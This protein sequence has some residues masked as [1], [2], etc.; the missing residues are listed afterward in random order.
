M[1]GLEEAESGCVRVSWL[2]N[3]DVSAKDLLATPQ[4]QEHADARSE[5]IEFLNEVLI[6]G[7]VAA[8][9]VKAEAEDAGIS[10]RTL[11]R[12]KKAIGIM[13]YREGETGE[14]GKGQWLW[15]L[16]VLEL[17][18]DNIKDATTIKDAKGCQNNNIGILNHT[19]DSEN[20]ESRIDKPSSLR[21]PAAEEGSI[22]DATTI[23]DAR[24]PGL[25]Y[26]GTLSRD[27]AEATKDAN[28]GTLKGC[29]HGL[30]PDVCKVCN[31]YVRHLIESGGT[32]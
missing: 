22:K 18:D 9:Q 15:K 7:P 14:R 3:T 16:P 17:V 12:A 6:D 25:E 28:V 32:A 21:M 2:G 31:G 11:A 23:K 27:E 13:S 20:A 24:V 8:S 10:E 5:A 29:I 1:F 30:T 4:D 19:G 26:G